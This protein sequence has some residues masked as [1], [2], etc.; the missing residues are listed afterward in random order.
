MT[1]KTLT[2]SSEKLVASNGVYKSILITPGKGSSGFY[3]E[4]MLRTFGPEAFPKGTHSYLNHLDEGEY[5]SPSQLMAVLT[6][7]A[8]YEDGVGLVA[9]IRPMK[10]WADFVEEVAPYVGMSISAQGTGEASEIDGE[11][12]FV[13]E[14]LLP[15][16]MNT[17][18]F[19][20]YA[21][22]GGKIAEQLAEQ[23]L[24]KSTH[25]DPS[26]GTGK[27]GNEIMATL[28]ENAS[29]LAEAAGKIVSAQEAAAVAAV[30]EA[31]TA[32]KV[33]EA[34][35]N[36][37]AATRKVAEAGLSNTLSDKLYAQIEAGDFSVEEKLTE[38][39]EIRSE[40]KEQLEESLPSGFVG[41]LVGAGTGST[42]NFNVSGW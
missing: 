15:D 41:S 22:R 25:T 13:V 33:A 31:E 28:E 6:E 20:S 38:Y 17:V 8:Y 39:E 30:S 32:E 18:D 37:V 19:V 35:K 29:A 23:A 24:N 36:A 40:V 16:V 4:E 42:K 5:R 1:S 27:K 34:I 14:S 2:E 7:D 12:V 21:G 9:N 26:A 3:S 10:H 11:Q